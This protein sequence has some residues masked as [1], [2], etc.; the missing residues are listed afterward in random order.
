MELTV[1]PIRCHSRNFAFPVELVGLSSPCGWASLTGN[2]E[3]PHVGLYRH[4][5]L[6]ICCKRFPVKVPRG[7]LIF[8]HFHPA[9]SSLLWDSEAL[10]QSA[11]HGTRPQ[12]SL[13]QRAPA[14]TRGAAAGLLGASSARG[15]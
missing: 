2:T 7:T 9:H 8:R 10:L 12:P 4:Q 6:L 15:R 14:T 13:D 3:Q 1:S 11:A 5:S